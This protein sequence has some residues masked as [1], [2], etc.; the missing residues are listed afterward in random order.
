M[1]FNVT[2]QKGV[3]LL[4]VKKDNDADEGLTLMHA[5][6][7]ADGAAVEIGK[8]GVFVWEADGS[9]ERGF[10]HTPAVLLLQFDQN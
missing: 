7:A 9:D 1:K 2:N 6:P 5:P 8:G 10:H 4:R 3:L